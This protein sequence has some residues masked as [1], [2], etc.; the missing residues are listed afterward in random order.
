MNVGKAIGPDSILVEIEKSLGEKGLEWITNFFTRI[1]VM[2]KAT[3]TIGELH[4][5]VTQ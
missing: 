3:T 4:C 2:P 1:R 5:L